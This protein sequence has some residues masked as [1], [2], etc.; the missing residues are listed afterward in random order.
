MDPVEDFRRRLLG[1][2][3]GGTLQNWSIFKNYLQQDIVTGN[4]FNDVRWGDGY[5]IYT[6]PVLEINKEETILVTQ[7]TFY[8]LGVKAEPEQH[9]V[10][11]NE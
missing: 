11:P 8:T 7:N 2:N 4:I 5:R 9:P 6:T 1:L 3:K 10:G